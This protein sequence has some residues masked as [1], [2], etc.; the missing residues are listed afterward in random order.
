MVVPIH[1][2]VTGIKL[3]V[4]E[5]LGTLSQ[6]AGVNSGQCALPPDTE[7]RCIP[8][9]FL[10]CNLCPCLWYKLWMN[11]LGMQLCP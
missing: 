9:V 1:W 4:R 2:E 6:Q 7:D 3:R 10:S 8:S 5:V 11:Q